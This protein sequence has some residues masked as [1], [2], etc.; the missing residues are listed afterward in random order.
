M[1]RNKLTL[2]NKFTYS[3]G[4]LGY[5]TIAQT[6]TNFIMFFGTSILGISGTLVGLAVAISAFWDGISDPLVG[7]LSDRYKIGGLGRRLGYMLIATIGMATINLLLWNVPENISTLGKFFWLLI[8][9]L[10]IETFNTFYATPYTALGIDIAPEYSQ[11]S[12]IQGFKTVFFIVGMILPSILMIIFMPSTDNVKQAQFLQ[13][14]YVNISY[15][16]SLLSL[17]C[18]LICIFGMLKKSREVDKFNQPKKDKNIFFKIFGN[19]FKTLKKQNFGCIIIG[20]SIALI[21]AAFLTSVGMHLFTYSFHFNSTQ[22]SSLMGG[23]F[24]GAIVSQPFWI[25]VANRVDKKKALNI[26]LIVVLF[27]LTITSCL[28]IIRQRIDSLMLFYLTLPC[29]FVCGFGTG[30]LY[31]LPVS[32]FADVITLEKIKTGENHSATYSGYMTL[33]FNIANSLA[34]FLIGILLDLIKFNPS[35][36]VQPLIVQNLLGVIVFAGCGLAIGLSMIFFSKYKLTR[37]DILK[38]QIKD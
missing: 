2:A 4:N 11:Q 13:S 33:A 19:F 31:S 14:G 7:Y 20:Y 26:S 25:Y 18:G 37:A 5:G 12:S 3:I 17:V 1:K 28:F 15:V 24:V 16:T 29:I 27:G 9:L 36:P 38:A 35:E 21:S 30:A 34:L 8:C 22:I 23:L 6:V 10:L 32:M